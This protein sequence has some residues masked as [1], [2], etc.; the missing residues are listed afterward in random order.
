MTASMLLTF[1][2]DLRHEILACEED[3]LDALIDF[4]R[5][6]MERLH[7]LAGL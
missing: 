3:L 5:F 4:E 6:L 1:I 2:T 7:S